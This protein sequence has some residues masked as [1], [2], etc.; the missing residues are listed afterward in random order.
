ME[1]GICEKIFKKK[2]FNIIKDSDKKLI[3]P[4]VLY[5]DGSLVNR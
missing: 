4:D 1:K 2:G 3:D 5:Q